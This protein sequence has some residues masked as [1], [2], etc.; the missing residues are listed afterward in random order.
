MGVHNTV[1]M[2]SIPYVSG[3]LSNFKSF[4]LAMVLLFR[5]PTFPGH[6]KTK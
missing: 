5:S 6:F 2:V 4:T 3:A 1:A